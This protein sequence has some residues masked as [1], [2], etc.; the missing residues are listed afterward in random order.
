MITWHVFDALHSE[1][2]YV[3][4]I[5]PHIGQG[6]LIDLNFAKPPS[7]RQSVLFHVFKVPA[8]L[9]GNILIIFFILSRKKRLLY[10]V[11]HNLT[12]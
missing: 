10:K 9:T 3:S 11:L 4:R 5:G 12:W 8:F 6:Q 7:T 2:I 1:F